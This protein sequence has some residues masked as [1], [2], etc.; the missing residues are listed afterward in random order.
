MTLPQRK[1]ATKAQRRLAA[2]VQG[3]KEIKGGTHSEKEC[4]VNRSSF[5]KP[6]SN[7]K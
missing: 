4:V 7:S 5:R 6:G 3:W 2:R 1:P